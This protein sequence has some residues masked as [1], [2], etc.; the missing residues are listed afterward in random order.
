MEKL[1]RMC[2]CPS[3]LIISSTYPKAT[4]VATT[5]SRNTDFSPQKQTSW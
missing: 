2:W 1:C 4:L 5:H 3:R